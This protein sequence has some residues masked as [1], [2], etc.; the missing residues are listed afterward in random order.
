MIERN[1]LANESGRHEGDNVQT[2]EAL[3]MKTKIVFVLAVAT[4]ALTASAAFAASPATYPGNGGKPPASGA[5]CRPQITVVLHGTIAT[6]PGSAPT[7]PFAL[8]VTVSS[9]N[10]HG[11]AFVKTT[12]PVTVTVTSST[13]I[14][15]QGDHKLADLLAGDLV[16]VQAR[17]CKADLSAAAAPS[18]S[19]TMI[20]AHPAGSGGDA[21]ETTQTTT[22]S[23]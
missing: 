15:R 4:A 23:S 12:Q 16:T 18:L 17:T 22:T 14:S 11:R 9:A 19:A 10:A 8:M 6:A 20:N 13:R 3:E 1:H 5:G 2:Q 21:T 7:L